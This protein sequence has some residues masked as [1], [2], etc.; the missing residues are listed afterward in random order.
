MVSTR[1]GGVNVWPPSL[2][3]TTRYWSSSAVSP[4]WKPTHSWPVLGLTVGSEPWLSLQALPARPPGA[5][6]AP[7]PLMSLGADHERAWSSEYSE[8]ICAEPSSENSE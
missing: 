5:Q 3:V 7:A 4:F 8:K 6:K 2:D 1:T